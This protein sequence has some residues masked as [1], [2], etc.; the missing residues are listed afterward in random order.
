M[1]KLRYAL[2][3]SIYL[4]VSSAGLAAD[5]DGVELGIVR[6]FHS[7]ILDETRTLNLYLPSS[8]GESGRSYP[9]I[10]LL[11]GAIHED[12]HHVSGLIQFLTAYELMPESILVGIAN[13]DRYRDFTHPTELP[14]FLERIP[15]SGNSPNFIRFL[16]EELV[17]FVDTEYRTDGTSTII[18][19]SLGGLL[20]AEVFLRSPQ[21]FD[22]YMI[23]SPSFWWDDYSLIGEIEAAI[24]AQPDRT[25]SLYLSLGTEGDEMQTGVDRF[26]AIL[27]NHAPDALK[28]YYAPFPEET[29]ATILHR[30][31]YRGFELFYEQTHP[32][33]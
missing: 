28:W 4:L 1:I 19:Q 31:L 17:P 24:P 16:D 8:Y 25:G 27:R 13:V 18:G 29:H 30:S 14:E 26:V 15:Q 23:V 5:G 10:F 22:N 20:V 12:Y 6:E 7:Q 11:D 2:V 32:G 21:T 9:V 3:L 33:L